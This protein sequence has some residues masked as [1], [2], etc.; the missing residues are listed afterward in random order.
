MVSTRPVDRQRN[1]PLASRNDT[2]DWQYCNVAHVFPHKIVSKTDVLL[3][4]RHDDK[5]SQLLR[6]LGLPEQSARKLAS[7]SVSPTNK[8][9]GVSIPYVGVQSGIE[10][11]KWLSVEVFWTV[12]II[13][14]CCYY[15]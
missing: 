7:I 12:I 3:Q 11:A 8:N 15:M 6:P 10:G 9:T 1:Q 2:H 5:H 4:P 14:C 13:I